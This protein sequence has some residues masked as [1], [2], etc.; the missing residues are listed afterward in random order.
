METKAWH[1]I[2]K[3]TWGEGPWQSEPDKLQWTTKS[4]LPG[5]VVRGPAG[6]LCGYAGVTQDH[7]AYGADYDALSDE[8]TVHGGLTFASFCHQGPGP[9]ATSVCHVPAEGEP[10]NVW[11]LGFDCAHSGDLCPAINAL[12]RKSPTGRYLLQ[13]SQVYRSLSYVKAHVEHLAAQLAGASDD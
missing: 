13:A 5:L 11:W 4:G 10:D 6:A 3:S 9:E 2:D 7:P 12:L 1:S 8:I